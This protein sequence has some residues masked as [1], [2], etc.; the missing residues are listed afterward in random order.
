M[1]CLANAVD[2]SAQLVARNFL[3]L[4]ESHS[5]PDPPHRPDHCSLKSERT[6]GQ[7][8]GD[9]GDGCAFRRY[10]ETAVDVTAGWAE[11]ADARF[12]L[13]PH[14]EPRA[15][16]ISFDSL[17]PLTA[18]TGLSAPHP[19]SEPLTRHRC[20]SSVRVGAELTRQ[21]QRRILPLGPLKFSD[22]L[23]RELTLIPARGVQF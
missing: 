21:E 18:V 6:G 17:S 19:G 22:L 23:T 2:Q 12:L 13:A 5:E 20:S 14:A 4:R 9:V 15:I 7:C 8:K 11:T 1:R 3:K 10:R 16:E